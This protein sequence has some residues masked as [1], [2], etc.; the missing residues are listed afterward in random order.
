MKPYIA[1]ILPLMMLNEPLYAQVSA[2]PEPPVA[3]VAVPA[4]APASAPTPAVPPS[5]VV[6]NIMAPL[7]P[8]STLHIAQANSKRDA[9]YERERAER[10][11]E[12]AQERAEREKERKESRRAPTEEEALALAA[13]EGL[14]SQPA[15]RALP[16][17]KK[18]LAGSQTRLVKE[19]ALFVLGQINKPEAQDI[20]LDFAR[21]PDNPLRNEAIRTIGIGGNTK[22]LGA[23]QDIYNAG[24]ATTKRRV[25]EA[26]LIAGRKGEVYQAALNAKT[27]SEAASA[28]RTLG[29]MGAGEELRKLGEHR[30]NSRSL[31]EAYAVAGD[32]TSLRKIAEGPGD[33]SLRVD[34]TRRIGI[35]NSEAARTALRDLY[36]ANGGAENAQLRDA[37]LQGMLVRN[38]QQG[39]LALYR[40]AKTNEEKRVLLRTLSIMGG[41]AA[42]AAIDAALEGKK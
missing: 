21:M 19:R 20:L 22:S 25:L 3:P 11:R 34:A 12:R 15:E 27:E 42:L 28:I 24:D 14:M 5:P 30:K 23:L 32:L 9:E 29:A 41:D 36:N 4:P 13:M 10:D 8:I 26:W 1:V 31:L 16:L 40:A 39:V 33:M 17:L 2:P 18:V 38:D 37:A 6:R 7:P 35:I